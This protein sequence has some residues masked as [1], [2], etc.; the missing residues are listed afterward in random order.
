[1]RRA[2]SNSSRSGDGFAAVFHMAL[3]IPFVYLGFE[4]HSMGNTFL[5]CLFVSIAIQVAQP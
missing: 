5:A 3:A 2:D 1:M 4:A